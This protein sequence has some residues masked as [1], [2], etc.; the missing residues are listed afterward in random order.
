MLS[1]FTLCKR[2]YYIFPLNLFSSPI[3]WFSAHSPFNAKLNVWSHVC[4]MYL[5]LHGKQV[6]FFRFSWFNFPFI[7]RYKMHKMCTLSTWLCVIWTYGFM[8]GSLIQFSSELNTSNQNFT[9]IWKLCTRTLS[10]NISRMQY[11]HRYAPFDITCAEHLILEYWAI[12]MQ[13]NDESAKWD[14]R[15][16]C[17]DQDELNNLRYFTFIVA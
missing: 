6:Y 7:P 14:V 12:S 9:L 13:K 17:N 1:E 11:Q 4:Y 10:D 15:S 3:C 16:E 5:H 8:C 2:T